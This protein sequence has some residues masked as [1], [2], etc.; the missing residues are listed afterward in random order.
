MEPKPMEPETMYNNLLN[1]SLGNELVSIYKSK[2]Y[3]DLLNQKIELYFDNARLN[4][5]KTSGDRNKE[6]EEAKVDDPDSSFDSFVKESGNDEDT[7]QMDQSSSS[8]GES[9]KSIKSSDSR[10]SSDMSVSSDERGDREKSDKEESDEE[11]MSSFFTSD[12]ID[13]QE[14]SRKIRP[15][16]PADNTPGRNN[17][18]R[19]SRP[20]SKT[21]VKSSSTRPGLRSQSTSTIEPRRSPRLTPRNNVGRPKS[22]TNLPKIGGKRKTN[23]MR[24]KQTPKRS[25]RRKS[26]N[27][28]SS[29]KRTHRK[30][31]TNKHTH[32]RRRR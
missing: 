29:R 8:D 17:S 26:K 19:S 32:T 30:T 4:D 11:E 15:I 21:P 16:V 23:K 18:S 14:D 28:R 24:R 22:A 3:E 6:E 13:E 20:S 12:A 9:V 31:N 1:S 27:T 5:N 7:V 2:R 10:N 25:M